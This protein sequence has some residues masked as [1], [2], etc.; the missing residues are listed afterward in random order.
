MPGLPA[1]HSASHGLDAY[2]MRSC[3]SLQAIAPPLGALRPPGLIECI[4]C[5]HSSTLTLFNAFFSVGANQS[6]CWWVEVDLTEGLLCH[7]TTTWTSGHRHPVQ[8]ALLSGRRLVCPAQHPTVK[9]AR[10]M[11]EGADVCRSRC[12]PLLLRV[13]LQLP[14]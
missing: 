2:C 3:T 7:H 5:D 10:M 1:C 4:L 11:S 12:R 13:P 6:D 8:H 9:H 14:P